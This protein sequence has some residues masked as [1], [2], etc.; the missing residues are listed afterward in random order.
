MVLI[1][2]RFIPMQTATAMA[3][4][5]SAPLYDTTSYAGYVTNN[6]DCDD[7]VATGFAINPDGAEVNDQHDNN[8]DGV[9]N[10]GPFAVGDYGPAGGIVFYVNGANGLKAAPA[11][12]D[13][14]TGVVWGC[15]GTN[16]AGASGSALGTGAQNTADILAANC[17]ETTTAAK[18]VDAYSLN[19]FDDW[20]L[21][22]LDESR[23][24]YAQRNTVGAFL[25][26]SYVRTYYWNSTET[27]ANYVL[28]KAFNTGLEQGMSKTIPLR[29]RA[30]RSF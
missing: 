7:S 5:M 6:L 8:C 26:G 16:I 22:S 13:S 29:V 23:T 30:I 21:P 1:C 24:L 27:H 28:A 20:Y 12:Q 4:K 14:G 11:D 10:D 15:Y 18:L 3:T 19:G 17:P 2:W 9:V 25:P